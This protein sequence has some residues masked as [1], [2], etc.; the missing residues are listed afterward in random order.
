MPVTIYACITARPDVVEEV[1]EACRSIVGECLQEDGVLT[2][3]L[4]RDAE[5]PRMFAWFEQWRAEE[6]FQRHISSPH[7]NRL[8]AAL[9]GK[10][11]GEMVI[12]RF[13]AL[14]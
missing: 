8:G 5:N 11:E 13:D 2:Y 10:I 14:V 12:K 9:D 4:L 1:E 6:A 3:H 7:A